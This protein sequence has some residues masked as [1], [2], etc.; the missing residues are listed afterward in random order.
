LY[1]FYI[2]CHAVYLNWTLKREID[3]LKADIV[4]IEQKNQ[5]LEN[6]IVYY[7]SSS[8][9]ELEARE[10][11]GL[12]KVGEKVVSVPVRKYENSISQEEERLNSLSQKT[13]KKVPN[14]RAWSA[15]IFQ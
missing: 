13:V 1:I 14:Y 11:L 15:F 6:L 5:N 3:H 2:L 7:K 12:K 9:K 10:K 8:F 4:S